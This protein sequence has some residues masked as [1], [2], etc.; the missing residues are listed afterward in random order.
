[1]SSPALPILFCLQIL[2]TDGDGVPNWTDLDDDN[3]GI[4]DTDEN[5]NCQK[6]NFS[7][8]IDVDNGISRYNQCSGSID[9]PGVNFWAVNKTPY[10]GSRYM[11][12]HHTE[13][14]SV[15]IPNTDPV[16]IGVPYRISI[17]TANATIAEWPSN[18]PA[19]MDVYAGTAN[20]ATSQLIGTTTLLPAAGAV[21]SSTPWVNDIFIFTPNVAYTHITFIAREAFTG[22]TSRGYLLVDGLSL[23]KNVSD[24]ECY[25]ISDLDGDGIPNSLDLDSDGDG[26]SDAIEGGAAFTTANLTATTALSGSVSS[27]AATLGVPVSA[28]T[29][30]GIGFSQISTVNACTDTDTDG[31]PDLDDLDDDNDGILDTAENNCSIAVVNKTGTVITKPSSINYTFNSN[32][33]AN[34]IDGVDNNVIVNA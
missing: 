7:L 1:L 30:Q 22:S 2:D 5:I 23:G 11:G 32:T 12:F 33:V 8:D 26:C 16:Q 29:G 4:L 25:L 27:A 3:D 34:L 28:G 14:M 21:G 31:I 19:Q 17:A 6:Y 10:T 18:F 20:C 24:Q 13:S 15:A 9:G